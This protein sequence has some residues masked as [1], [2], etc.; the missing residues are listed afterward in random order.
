MLSSSSKNRAVSAI[1][2]AGGK[3]SRMGTDKALLQIE[4]EYL[5][6]RIVRQLKAHFSDIIVT[7]GE[8]KRYT[9][10]LDVPV[11]E[12]KIKSCGP[13]GGLYTG[14]EAATNEY[15]FVTAC[16]MPLLKPELVEFLVEQ[17]DDSV[18]AIVPEVEGVRCVTR[19]IYSK[20][21]ISVIRKLI[22]EG[23]FSLQ[24]LIDLLSTRVVLAS[25]LRV[26]DS[27]FSSFCGV[28]N[29]S[30]WKVIHT[31]LQ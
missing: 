8:T 16:D 21:C 31:R 10:L 14:L 6:Q 25:E 19:A 15:S 24:G 2:L 29:I 4:G 11:L 20:S 18:D 26:V 9:D 12:D 7:T 5:I 22:E 27:Y 30:E 1:V 28:N 13:M 17:I 3:S 23:Q